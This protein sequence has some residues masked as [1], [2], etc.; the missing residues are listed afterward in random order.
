MTFIVEIFLLTNDVL[1]LQ[2]S[3]PRWS[4]SGPYFLAFRL[5]TG[6]D[7]VNLRIQS[8]CGEI[9]TRK[10]PNTDTFDAAN[11]SISVYFEI[12]Q[13]ILNF[14]SASVSTVPFRSYTLHTIIAERQK[15][16]S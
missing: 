5:D 6:I 15:I 7:S 4:F 3:L 16:K 10:T 12:C 1:A 13:K 11:I 14:F 9:W 8:E 2:F